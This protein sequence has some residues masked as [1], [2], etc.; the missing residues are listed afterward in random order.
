MEKYY[1]YIYA[2]GKGVSGVPFIVDSSDE[3]F[4]K[5]TMIRDINFS[6]YAKIGDS[7]KFK[8]YPVLKQIGPI[9][10]TTDYLIKN[11][12]KK[13]RSIFKIGITVSNKE[14]MEFYRFNSDQNFYIGFWQHKIDDNKMYLSN[15]D[16]QFKKEYLLSLIK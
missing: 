1:F 10:N 7:V 16:L 8:I 12:S 4:V 6:L 9:Y 11:R 15:P 2:V 14:N 3:D 5:M 13:C